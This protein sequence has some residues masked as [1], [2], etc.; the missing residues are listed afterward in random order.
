MPGLSDCIFWYKTWDPGRLEKVYFC[1]DGD[2]SKWIFWYE[3][4]APGGGESVRFGPEAL[5][6]E[7][8]HILV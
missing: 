5:R 6:L 3:M 1:R 8:L 7:G 4:W 2:R